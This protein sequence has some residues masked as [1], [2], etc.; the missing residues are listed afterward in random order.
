[1]K[2][3]KSS[4]GPSAR[5]IVLRIQKVRKAGDK[6]SKNNGR[7]ADYRY[8][9][10][11]LR[12]YR[13]FEDQQLMTHLVETAPSV[14]MTPVRAGC[15][16][17]RVIIDATCIQPDLRLGSRWTRALPYAASEGIEPEDLVRFIR[18]HNGIAGCADL[19]SKTKLKRDRLDFEKERLLK[20]ATGHT[21]ITLRI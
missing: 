16:P 17:L 15:H 19:A 12:A 18:A 13:Y 10:A 7:F 9:R 2:I 6:A 11:V 21:Q 14:L 1:M 5:K 4:L 3:Q 20:S 8:L